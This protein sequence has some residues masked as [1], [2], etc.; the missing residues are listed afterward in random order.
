MKEDKC[1]A[2]DFPQLIAYWFGELPEAQQSQIEEHVFGCEHCTQR[3]Q[4]L[5]EVGSGVQ[6]IVGQ[7][8]IGFLVTQ[9]FIDRL[10]AQGMRIREYA[11]GPGGSVNC[12]IT[13][14]DDFVISRLKA[15]LTD[16]TRLD[17]EI[18]TGDAPTER[19]KDILFDATAGEV[20]SVPP[21][22]MIRAIA[23]PTTMRMR[24]LA[25]DDAGERVIG[26]YHFNHAPHVA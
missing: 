2:V 23:A 25:V 4:F 7:G 12:T 5:A 11:M 8:A 14:Q 18:Q 16:V 9:P 17:V 1:T 20:V 26:E 10:R 19:R 21:A 13:P 15:P 22:V 3:L 6:A 24:L